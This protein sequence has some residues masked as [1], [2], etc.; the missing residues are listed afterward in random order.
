[1]KRYGLFAALL[2]LHAMYS[3]QQKQVI[4]LFSKDKAQCITVIDTGGFRYI[5]DGEQNRVPVKNFVKLDVGNV[6]PLG[7]AIHVCWENDKYEWDV[8]VDKSKIIESR[9]DSVR[10]RVNTSLPQDD[11]GIPTEIKFRAN[12]CM[13]FSYYLMKLSPENGGIVEIL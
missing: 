3:C 11:R 5:V 7:D 1:M 6:D 8:A 13:V 12:G 4:H 10:F 2:V 9:L